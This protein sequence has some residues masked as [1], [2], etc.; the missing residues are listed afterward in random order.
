MTLKATN[1]P[2]EV[3]VWNAIEDEL[4]TGLKNI[5]FL[6]FNYSADRGNARISISHPKGGEIAKKV[7]E[8]DREQADSFVIKLCE[9]FNIQHYNL[10]N[11]QFNLRPC[12]IPTF[13]AQVYPYVSDESTLDKSKSRMNP[14]TI[15]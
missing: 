2:L 4:K 14:I 3:D 9:R 11:L 15:D 7:V 8:L 13:F 12:E 6:D 5:I 10:N 1:I